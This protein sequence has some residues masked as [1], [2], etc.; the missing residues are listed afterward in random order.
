MNTREVDRAERIA[1]WRVDHGQC[2]RCGL[3]ATKGQLCDADFER[4]FEG[5]RVVAVFYDVD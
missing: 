2:A 1:R 5:I 3:P 4:A